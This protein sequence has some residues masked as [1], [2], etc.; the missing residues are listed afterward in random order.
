M[1][2]GDDT[3]LW[4]IMLVTGCAAAVLSLIA[5][6]LGRRNDADATAPQRFRLNMASYALLS[7][8]ILSFVARGFLLPQ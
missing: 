1:T 3:V 2:A 5:A 6:A 7:V 8:S 4:W